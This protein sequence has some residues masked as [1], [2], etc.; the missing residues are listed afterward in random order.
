MASSAQEDGLVKGDA[1]RDDLYALY[2]F[3][4]KLE[5]QPERPEPTLAQLQMVN[6]AR[7]FVTM[8]MRK[9]A[10]LREAKA[11]NKDMLKLKKMLGH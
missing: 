5:P 10:S 4:L 7:S 1:Q 8:K 9:R 11:Q 2:E 3:A 6:R